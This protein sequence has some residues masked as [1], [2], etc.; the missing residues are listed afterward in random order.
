MN[1]SYTCEEIAA[2]YHRC[3]ETIRGW[4]RNGELP[5]LD[6]GGGGNGPY[7]VLGEDLAH[8]EESRKVASKAKRKL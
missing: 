7:V 2:R 3:K 6:V 1:E 8:F 4:I 5:A